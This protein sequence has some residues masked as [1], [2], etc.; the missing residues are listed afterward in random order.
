MTRERF[1]QMRV[2]PAELESMRFDDFLDC[3]CDLFRAFP[4]ACA[5]SSCSLRRHG[6][7]TRSLVLCNVVESKWER[8]YGP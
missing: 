8:I 4:H 1:S 6:C 3:C 5:C 2:R 7:Q